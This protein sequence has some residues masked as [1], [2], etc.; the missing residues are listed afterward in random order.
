[1]ETADNDRAMGGDNGAQRALSDPSLSVS[2]MDANKKFL[3][4][5]IYFL[6]ENWVIVVEGD[7]LFYEFT[8]GKIESSEHLFGTSL[9][10]ESIIKYISNIFNHMHIVEASAAC[11][12]KNNT[13]TQSLLLDIEKINFE[14]FEEL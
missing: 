8:N 13:F 14:K 6:Y 9:N 12:H 7:G 11:I 1:M 5:R 2:I 4:L 3:S 10:T